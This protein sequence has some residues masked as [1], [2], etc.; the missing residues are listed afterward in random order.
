MYYNTIMK[1]LI[2]V[3]TLTGKMEGIPSISTS[4]R[5]NESC[6]KNKK[7]PGSICSK[8]YS[9]NTLK[10]RPIVGEALARN[11]KLLGGRVLDRSEIP[12]LNYAV[13]RFESHGDVLNETHEENLCRIAER[14][15]GTFFVQWTKRFS[16]VEKFFDSRAKPKNLRLIYSSLMMSTRLD[17]KRFRHADKIFTVWPRQ[18]RGASWINCAKSCASCMTCYTPGNNVRYIDEIVK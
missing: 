16:L 2:H 3:S 6:R 5:L 11:S 4:P 1:P 12:F 13:F 8:C 14:N 17:I 9:F 18:D 10:F 15:P 7:I